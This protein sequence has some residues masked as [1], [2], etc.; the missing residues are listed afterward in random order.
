[1]IEPPDGW[2]HYGRIFRPE[3]GS[4]VG[5]SVLVWPTAEDSFEFVPD[6]IREHQLDIRTLTGQQARA[7][8]A[9]WG[10]DWM[11]IDANEALLESEVFGIRPEMDAW[12]ATPLVTSKY[13]LV[14]T[15]P[16]DH[17]VSI[18]AR[19]LASP[20]LTAFGVLFIV[21]G[22]AF[23]FD[24]QAPWLSFAV[25]CGGVVLMW[26]A[27]RS[28]LLAVR[29]TENEIVVRR[30]VS[31]E[32]F[33]RDAVVGFGVAPYSGGLESALYWDV[34]DHLVMLKLVRVGSENVPIGPVFGSRKAVR[35]QAAALSAWLAKQDAINLRTGESDDR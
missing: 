20:F 25:L 34:A 7:E 12:S 35:R 23:V 28:W 6:T 8:L 27:I 18:G 1:M 22:F 3:R 29:I 15:D 30:W 14:V 9:Q 21:C 16:A 13:P 33:R 11:P 19:V 32:R 31:A 24:G 4:F 17:V 10:G 5:G 2:G 26:F